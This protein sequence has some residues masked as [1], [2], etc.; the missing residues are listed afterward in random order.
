MTAAIRTPVPITA[1][2][3]RK[4]RNPIL[5]GS[6]PLD[7]ARFSPAKLQLLLAATRVKSP[8]TKAALKTPRAFAVRRLIGKTQL[9]KPLLTNKLFGTNK[10]TTES[11]AYNG[12]YGADQSGK[13]ELKLNQKWSLWRQYLS[14]LHNDLYGN[15]REKTRRRGAAPNSRTT[16]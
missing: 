5:L 4:S 3:G 15:R 8:S 16:R 13:L 1:A 6:M 11:S 10:Y 9:D 14:N 7:I 2:I 12:T